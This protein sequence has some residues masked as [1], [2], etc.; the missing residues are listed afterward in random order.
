MTTGHVDHKI[1]A[2]IK[3]DEL[4][5]ILA[6]VSV[7]ADAEYAPDRLVEERAGSGAVMMN[8]NLFLVA[9][10]GRASHVGDRARSKTALEIA[11][12]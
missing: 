6:I 8:K 10:I 7:V 12:P 3:L 9:Y 1:A 2:R 4:C 5:A 11:R